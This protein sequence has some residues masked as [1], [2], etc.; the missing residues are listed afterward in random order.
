MAKERKKREYKPSSG[1]S[2]QAVC[3]L[4]NQTPEMKALIASVR[5]TLRS[6]H[7][8][9]LEYTVRGDETDPR[10]RVQPYVV[11]RLNNGSRTRH[12]SVP[13]TL[14]VGDC[15]STSQF[16]GIVEA[17]FDVPVD[18]RFRRKKVPTYGVK[19]EG[20]VKQY[21]DHAEK[22]LLA[23]VGEDARMAA[24][25]LEGEIRALLVSE[26]VEAGKARAW[27]DHVVSKIRSVLLQFKA[28]PQSTFKRALDEF[29]CH[30]IM[31]A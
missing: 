3:N 8:V 13:D 31:E 26:E 15:Y 17:N 14:Y 25:K 24:R 5:D 9:G 27:E 19:K 18:P 30:E 20:I 10:R 7:V 11:V 29:I 23:A 28:E 1:P 4:L 2:M 6:A 16:I 22:Y 21:P 12:S